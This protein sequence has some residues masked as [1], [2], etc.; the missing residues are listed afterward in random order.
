MYKKRDSL[1]VTMSPKY[2]TRSL[3]VLVPIAERIITIA[4]R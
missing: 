2:L 3:L 4:G 1:V